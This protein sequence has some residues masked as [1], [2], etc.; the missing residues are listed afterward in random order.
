MCI[1]P[2]HELQLSRHRQE[3]TESCR[4]IIRYIIARSLLASWCTCASRHVR[5]TTYGRHLHELFCDCFMR[6]LLEALHL[7][8][9]MGPMLFITNLDVPALC[10]CVASCFIRQLPVPPA[11]C[12][13]A[14]ACLCGLH[15]VHG[16]VASC[17]LHHLMFALGGHANSLE[18]KSGAYTAKCQVSW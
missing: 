7:Q 17:M 6:R 9:P 16:R 3:L 5:R 13:A 15:G 18:G 10:K 12:G 8:L 4:S 11:L 2:H 14:G 1:L